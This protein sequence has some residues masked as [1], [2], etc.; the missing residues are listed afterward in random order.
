MGLQFRKDKCVQMHI[1]KTHNKEICTDGQ[2]DVWKDTLVTKEDGLRGA[3]NGYIGYK[4]Y[5]T[6]CLPSD[7]LGLGNTRNLS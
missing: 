6:N 7:S 3:E 5:R 2:V 1:E 4:I